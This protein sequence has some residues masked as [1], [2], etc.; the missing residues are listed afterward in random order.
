MKSEKDTALL[1]IIIHEGKNRQVRRMVGTV[2]FPAV[3]LKRIGFAFLRLDGL[4]SGSF[5][6]LSQ[7]EVNRLREWCGI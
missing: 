4:T 2:G 3:A 7:E 5:R 6:P 1:E